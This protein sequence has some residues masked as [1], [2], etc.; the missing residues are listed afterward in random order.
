M[1]NE[2]L[3][4]FEIAL[5]MALCIT[6]CY[7]TYI[8]A[9]RQNLAQNVIRLHI[10][11]SSD[12]AEDQA[13]KMR[14]KEGVEDYLSLLL[15][16]ASDITEATQIISENLSGIEGAAK[17]CSDGEAVAAQFGRLEY[18]TRSSQDYTLPAGEYTSLRVI[19]GEGEGHNWWGVIF[20]D[21]S[22]SGSEYT[23]AGAL[24]DGSVRIITQTQESTGVQ[25]KF[26]SL[27]Y[28]NSIIKFFRGE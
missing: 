8:N 16:D 14:V 9:T 1:K 6:L 7:G 4:K 15:Q 28:L 23:E 20:P 21:L 5:L 11:A 26:K 22:P 27:E 19:I 25:I 24:S 13:L 18:P 2:K 3:R 12:D 17:A 10:I